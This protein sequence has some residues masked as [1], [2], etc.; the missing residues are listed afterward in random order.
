M[1]GGHAMLLSATLGATDRSRYK[2]FG[3]ERL[4]TI[5]TPQPTQEAPV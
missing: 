5:D 3:S 1:A 2:R 4:K